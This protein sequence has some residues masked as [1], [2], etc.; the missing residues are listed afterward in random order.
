MPPSS[1]GMRAC[2]PGVGLGSASLVRAV[3]N[4]TVAAARFFLPS[5]AVLRTAKRPVYAVEV[6]GYMVL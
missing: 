6:R 4:D 5:Y 3:A 1:A 2:W